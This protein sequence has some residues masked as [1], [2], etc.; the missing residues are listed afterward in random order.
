MTA[1]GDSLRCSRNPGSNLTSG[2]IAPRKYRPRCRR[3]G[4]RVAKFHALQVGQSS[5]ANLTEHIPVTPR[6]VGVKRAPI[7]PVLI[8]PLVAGVYYIVV[9]VAFGLSI[10][11]ALGATDIDLSDST[12]SP[13]WASHWFYRLVAEVFSV[14]VGTFIAAGLARGRER[15]AAVT[16]GLT[17]SLGFL[18]FW[19]GFLI[20]GRLYDLGWSIPD[21]R[22][23]LLPEP[24][25]QHAIDGLMIISSPIVGMYVS[26]LARKIN[27]Q[28]PVGFA[29]INRLHF[30]W[31][32]IGAFCY[33]LGL[34]EPVSHLL[35]RPRGGVD[36]LTGILTGLAANAIPV[37]ALLIPG[38]YG[39]ALLSGHK[40][41]NLHLVTRNLL[42]VIVLVVGFLIVAAIQY[43]LLMVLQQ[44]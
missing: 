35:T 28:Q 3:R 1:H 36:L 33:A 16:G 24:W 18:T 38:F 31:L 14:A 23:Y 21:P 39:L 4:R 7:W 6:T 2:L 8:A 29:G 20:F 34:I 10:V 40:G 13:I 15:A 30:L 22:D 27:V 11:S 26:K 17:I 5:V 44:D 43:G 12:A 41:S 19:I 32:W 37:I 9:K 25:Y 42:G